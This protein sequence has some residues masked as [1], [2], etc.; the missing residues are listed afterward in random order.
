MNQRLDNCILFIDIIKPCY[1]KRI[2]CFGLFDWG[3]PNSFIFLLTM[4][5][6][7]DYNISTK[8]NAYHLTNTR[9]FLTTLH[10]Q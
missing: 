4:R 3:K 6:F 1:S 5:Y 7:F 10:W 9:A 8:T 2:I